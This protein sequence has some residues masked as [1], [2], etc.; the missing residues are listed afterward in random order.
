M[1]DGEA[2]KSGSPWNYLGCLP[3]CKYVPR[4]LP[5]ESEDDHLQEFVWFDTFFTVE[6]FEKL[7][8]HELSLDVLVI[9]WV[10]ITLIFV[11]Y[12]S[13]ERLRRKFSHRWLGDHPG[14]T[15]VFHQEVQN[16]LHHEVVGMFGPED[17]DISTLGIVK[18]LDPLLTEW[19]PHTIGKFY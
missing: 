1:V 15:Q 19:H 17:N 10:V 14:K 6:F 4:A 11:P 7:E 16:S 8:T 2:P 9:H 5:P 18:L 12:D 13:P 3:S